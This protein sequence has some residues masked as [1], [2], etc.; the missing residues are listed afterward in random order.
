MPEIKKPKIIVILGPTASGK[1]DLSIKLAKNF[2]GQIICSDS[3]QI[4]KYMDLGT[5]KIS[6]KEMQGIKHYML[7]I[8]N[9]NDKYSVG[10][11]KKDATICINKVLKNKKLPFLVGGSAMYLYSI[12]NGQDFPETQIDWDKRKAL[13]QKPLNE[14]LDILE[15]LDPK[16]FAT[17]QK[18]NKRRVIRAIEI[19]EQ[20]GSVP[21]I[22]NNPEFDC[23]L[24]G[25]KKEGDNLRQ[26]IKKRIL[27][28]IKQGMIDEVKN[29]HDKKKISWEKLDEFG[30]EYRWIAKFLQNQITKDEMLMHLEADIWR[31]SKHQMNWFNKDKN[32]NWVKTT[33][34]AKNLIHNFINQN[35]NIKNQNDNAKCK[36]II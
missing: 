4:Y 3:R 20:F 2:N 27:K 13:E 28:R 1:T 11:F 15:N 26:A 17:V 35:S 32:I 29:L 33:S 12:I 7:D 34:Q 36:I 5:G 6:K 25:I 9:P 21:E 23:L 30:L 22:I 19:A 8:L 31:F 14:L 10:Q 24:I 18:Q 16:R